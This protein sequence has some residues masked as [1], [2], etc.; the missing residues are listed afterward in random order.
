MV[1]PILFVVTFNHFSHSVT[2]LMILSATSRENV[3]DSVIIV[4]LNIP[5]TLATLIISL[6]L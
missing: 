1:R 2:A 6:D 5:E 3:I 4:S